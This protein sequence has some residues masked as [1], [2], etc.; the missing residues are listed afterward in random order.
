MFM[1]NHLN[2]FG[3]ASSAAASITQTDAAVDPTDRTDY[4][5]FFDGKSI[6]AA[7]DRTLVLVCVSR[8]N[9]TAA[10]TSVTIGGVSASLIINASASGDAGTEI[11]AAAGVSGT[12]A[13]IDVVFPAGVGNCGI[14]VYALYNSA[15][16]ATDTGSSLADP[17]S[18]TI[19][20]PA[21]GV[22]VASC[23][24]RIV[25]VGTTYTWAGLTENVDATIE[26]AVSD[27]THS[28]A[29]K[30]FTAAQVGLTVSSTPSGTNAAQAMVV[31]SFGPN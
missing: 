3:V 29:S 18:D 21:N 10:A 26:D 6:G 17:M 4:S 11:W 2:G 27:T 9:I 22:A 12:T 24:G 7:A 8:I 31:A 15:T 14:V 30:A 16:V 1:V 25:A 13:D 23:C 19:N 28:A 5:G 20:V